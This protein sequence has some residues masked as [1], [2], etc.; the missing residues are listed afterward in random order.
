MSKK[1]PLSCIHFGEF[2]LTGHA[3]GRV[4]GILEIFYNEDVT[5]FLTPEALSS[6]RIAASKA[7]VYESVDP[8]FSALMHSVLCNSMESPDPSLYALIH[9]VFG[10]A[11]VTGDGKWGATLKERRACLGF[12]FQGFLVGASL[13]EDVES[14][15]QFLSIQHFSGT[16]DGIDASIKASQHLFAF[17][18]AAEPM[19]V[20]KAKI[21]EAASKANGWFAKLFSK[22]DAATIDASAKRVANR[23]EAAKSIIQ[24]QVQPRSLTFK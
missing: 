12:E 18:V 11:V 22:N 8:G 21:S 13:L 23:G 3:L 24:N 6:A 2:G 15:V 14:K 10:N 4:T 19:C 9:A 20:E 17:L 16:G 5:A 7:K 1:S